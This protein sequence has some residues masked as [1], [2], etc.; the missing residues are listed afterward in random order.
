MVVR[1]RSFCLFECKS[2]FC[3]NASPHTWSPKVRYQRS[4]SSFKQKVGKGYR[5]WK[6][7][8]AFLSLLCLARRER[9]GSYK[10][11]LKVTSDSWWSVE[12]PSC[13][14][15]GLTIHSWPRAMVA[16]QR[17]AWLVK[18]G[19]PECYRLTFVCSTCN[20]HWWKKWKWGKC[21]LIGAE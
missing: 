14:P 7:C 17:K 4:L 3:T 6:N 12:I 10:H 13:M 16:F 8:G 9:R 20:L 18:P 15:C 1:S 2:H 5:L 11:T 19:L 21:W